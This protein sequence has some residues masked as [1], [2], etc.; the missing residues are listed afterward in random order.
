MEFKKE[1]KSLR[2]SQSILSGHINR[3]VLN[4]TIKG[5]FRVNQRRILGRRTQVVNCSGL[6]KLWR[7]VV[8]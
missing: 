1:R 4:V 2:M 3:V 8:I 7:K 5:A 6:I